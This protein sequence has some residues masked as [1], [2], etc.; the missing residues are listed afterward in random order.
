MTEFCNCGYSIRMLKNLETLMEPAVS[1]EIWLF[2]KNKAFRNS[3]LD[4][5]EMWF[6]PSA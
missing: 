1:S 3:S 4:S 5:N 6:L 2:N